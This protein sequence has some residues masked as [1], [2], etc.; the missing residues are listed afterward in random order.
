MYIW[1]M[2]C[3]QFGEGATCADF[4]WE[5]IWPYC[6]FMN[7]GLTCLPTVN[8]VENIGFDAAVTHTQGGY[9]LGIKGGHYSFLSEKN[10]LTLHY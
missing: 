1:E 2:L 4:S 8:H 3:H 10:R 6:C 5:Y 7:H 9:K